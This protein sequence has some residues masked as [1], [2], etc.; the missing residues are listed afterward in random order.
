MHEFNTRQCLLIEEAILKYRQG[1]LG[2]NTLVNQ[3]DALRAALSDYEW[4]KKL[5]EPVLDLERINS[6][7]IAEQRDIKTDEAAKVDSILESIEELLL[8]QKIA[9]GTQ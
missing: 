1:Q 9:T 2:L 5:F 7:L 3:I 6:K 4:S 8:Q